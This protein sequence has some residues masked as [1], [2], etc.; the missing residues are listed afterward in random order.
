ML[1]DSPAIGERVRLAAL[2]SKPRAKRIRARG[3]SRE[4]TPKTW[5]AHHEARFAPKPARGFPAMGEAQSGRHD[6]SRA[7]TAPQDTAA[8]AA[9]ETAELRSVADFVR[10]ARQPSCA[11]IPNYRSRCHDLRADSR[12]HCSEIAIVELCKYLQHSC[13]AVCLIVTNALPYSPVRRTGTTQLRVCRAPSLGE[14]C[15]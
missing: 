14:P 9:G 8:L 4:E 6:F 11:L 12:P 15:R 1:F 10:S 13:K 3:I 7:T 5:S 2:L